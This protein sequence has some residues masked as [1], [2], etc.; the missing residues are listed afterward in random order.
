MET[1][2]EF[3]EELFFLNDSKKHDALEMKIED[4]IGLLEVVEKEMFL[5]NTT[6][7]AAARISVA[8]LRELVDGFRH[9]V[10]IGDP[11]PLGQQILRPRG[12]PAI[13]TPKQAPNKES[14]N[15]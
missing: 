5:L 1:H 8:C 4:A 15:G 10:Y 13:G 12:V 11:D 7:R 2:A 9:Y 3:L 6:Q 14:S